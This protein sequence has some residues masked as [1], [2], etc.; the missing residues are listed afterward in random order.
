MLQAAD[1]FSRMMGCL[2]TPPE[3]LVVFITSDQDFAATITQLKTR[4]FRVEVIYH[5]PITSQRAIGIKN[6]AHA[7]Y[8]WL[9]FLQKGL[10]M[11]LTIAPY[12]ESIK[13]AGAGVPNRFATPST[14]SRL[15]GGAAATPQSTGESN[16]SDRPPSSGPAV[17]G[18]AGQAAGASVGP[19]NPPEGTSL[20]LLSGWESTDGSSP[21]EQCIFLLKAYVSQEAADAANIA[22]SDDS[23]SVVVE[24]STLPNAS[25]QAANAAVLLDG[26]AHRDFK[27]M[28]KILPCSHA[29]LAGRFSKWQRS[30]S[31][32]A[33]PSNSVAAV[34]TNSSSISSKAQQQSSSI[35]QQGPRAGQ[36]G[37]IFEQQG[38]NTEQKGFSNGQQGASLGQQGP[39]FTQQGPSSGQQGFKF[40]QQGS[41]FGQQGFNFG[42]QNFN[43]GQQGASLGQQGSGF[44]QQG[45]EP[46]QQGFKFGQQGPSN[47]QQGFGQKQQGP[48]TVYPI[49]VKQNQAGNGQCANH[50]QTQ[51]GSSWPKWAAQPQQQQNFR[52]VQRQPNFGKVQPIKPAGAAKG[53]HHHGAG[54]HHVNISE[55]GKQ[56]KSAE[57][58]KA[59]VSKVA[60][61]NKADTG[62]PN[63]SAGSKGSNSNAGATERTG[64]AKDN[65]NQ[66]NVDLGSAAAVGAV[67]TDSDT[68]NDEFS[69]AFGLG[70]QSAEDVT[71]AKWGFHSA[72]QTLETFQ[73]DQIALLEA[74]WNRLQ[75][76]DA[77]ERATSEHRYF[78][79]ICASC[80]PSAQ[81]LTEL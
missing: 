4:H 22:V 36:H 48:N 16:A 21:E 44:G 34:N 79:L 18:Q 32:A 54:H 31:A 66:P 76:V 78:L 8:D 59:P 12:D 53:K 80:S 69:A 35:G 3:H 46:G 65:C 11:P 40:G 25:Q 43:N 6:T 45:F 27:V 42:Q 49:P 5:T 60:Q 56:P 10:N 75:C 7:S 30:S 9:D 68:C 52:P 15:H 51:A 39:S 47:G 14:W 64:A 17:S 72:I 57:K 74:Q 61:P 33:G 63:D 38:S 77:A 73:P 24:F 67:N 37:P 58:G 55:W 62:R 71:H 81:R 26:T 13:R 23:K 20:L 41:G 70:E 2:T 28:A 50:S 29:A 19:V 1:R